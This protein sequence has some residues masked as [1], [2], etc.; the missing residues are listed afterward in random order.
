MLIQTNY[1]R[2]YARGK[3]LR[4]LESLKLLKLQQ[5]LESERLTI[6]REGTAMTKEDHL[7]S[8]VEKHARALIREKL[9]LQAL[10]WEKSVR[11][12][13]FSM[14]SLLILRQVKIQKS[15]RG[16][17]AR[18]KIQQTKNEL[19]ESYQMKLQDESSQITRSLPSFQKVLQRQGVRGNWPVP[20][21]A[22]VQQEYAIDEQILSFLVP[23]SKEKQQLTATIY[24][25][26]LLFPMEIPS[27]SVRK[28]IHLGRAAK[29]SDGFATSLTNWQNRHISSEKQSPSAYSPRYFMQLIS[30]LPSQSAKG[31]GVEEVPS[32]ESKVENLDLAVEGIQDLHFLESYRHSPLKRLVLN[33]NNISSLEVGTP[34]SS[35]IKSSL[36]YLS[37]SDNKL[38]E[39]PVSLPFQSLCYLNL[40]SNRLEH[41]NLKNLTSLHVLS[42]NCNSLKSFPLLSSVF[43]TKLELYYNQIEAFPTESSYYQQIPSLTYL[44]LGKNLIKHIPCD[45]INSHLQLLNILILSQNKVENYP[46]A[47]AL[48][49]LHALWLNG[50]K[51]SGFSVEAEQNSLHFLPQLRKLYLQDNQLSSLGSIFQQFPVLVE[52][53]LSFNQFQ[54]LHGLRPL[55]KCFFLQ[56]IRLNDNP[57]GDVV[58]LSVLPTTNMRMPSSMEVVSEWI[59]EHFVC[60]QSV[61][62]ESFSRKPKRKQKFSSAID[63]FSERERQLIHFLQMLKSEYD[64]LI[65]RNRKK[66]IKKSS[67][68]EEYQNLLMN[69]K[70]LACLAFMQRKKLL[71][72]LSGS[73][74][75]LDNFMPQDFLFLFSEANPV[76]SQSKL[77]QQPTARQHNATTERKSE[78]SSVS[79]MRLL[80]ESLQEVRQSEE[81]LKEDQRRAAQQ[82]KLSRSVV[83][84]QACFRGFRLR[85]KIQNYLKTIQYEDDELDEILRPGKHD[86]AEDDLLDLDELLSLEKQF[87]LTDLPP[88]KKPSSASMAYGDH[89][90]KR[91]LVVGEISNQN[92]FVLDLPAPNAQK[93]SVPPLQAANRGAIG[94]PMS[95]NS[96]ASSA[97]TLS[98][99]MDGSQPG[100][101]RGHSHE[102]SVF[103]SPRQIKEADHLSEDWGI[104]DPKVLATLMKRN[105]KIKNFLHAKE[106]REKEKDPQVRYE[107][108]LKQQQKPPQMTLRGTVKGFQKGK[109]GKM[110]RDHVVIPAWMKGGQDQDEES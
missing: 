12:L 63:H 53:D 85:K 87:E 102:G 9:K 26:E 105:N 66:T 88:A 47:L 108:F 60:M 80:D 8:L 37:I 92:G 18:R 56:T 86:E 78:F 4:R 97:K 15:F 43:L 84:L 83:R 54:S 44:N 46:S 20:S 28:S 69:E 33:V 16:S 34:F 100:T 73:S 41:L 50:N 24:S 106:N 3:Y 62:G 38:T 55:Q 72:F 82:E 71:S 96:V 109:N 76:A 57:L 74:S 67:A 52:I 42:V 7:S 23:K 68:V 1:R 99:E 64:D 49:C 81:K 31:G 104:V 98:G 75:V 17:V 13:S 51:I 35:Q 36:E 40:D 30:P 39:V 61:N 19:D 27:L 6:L 79:L 77:T 14:R 21:S 45:L 32:E 65:F 29:R 110:T 101:Q 89:I 107:K 94:T 103:K 90:R 5:Q 2:Y 59:S 58:S 48:P 25:E 93:V 91:N 22:E 70:S 10:Q 11:K 95:A